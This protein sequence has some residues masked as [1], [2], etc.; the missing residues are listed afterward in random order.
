MSEPLE[1]WRVFLHPSQRKIVEKDYSGP[2][3]VLGGAGTGK[4]VVAMHRAK[5]LSSQGKGKE[6]ILLTTFTANLAADIR[7][8]FEKSAPWRNN[9]IDV[10]N[11]DAW[12]SQYL[13]EHGYPNT[14]VY[15]NVLDNVWEEAVA[16]SG[17]DLGLPI[18]FFSE[19]WAKVV[20]AEAFTLEAYAK[21]SRLGRGTR[22]DRKKRMQVWHVFEEYKNLLKE[23]HI[24]DVDSALFRCRLLIEKEA[25]FR[26]TR[27]LSSTKGRISACLPIGFFALWLEKNTEMIC[28]LWV[29]PISE[30]T[31]GRS[32][33]QS[34]ALMCADAAAF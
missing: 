12:V 32:L 17:E 8:L 3:R 26:S 11:L 33:F 7:T 34:V 6:R 4:T 29:I 14:I 27:A 25:L 23:R 2:V 31:K 10:I 16:L 13:R 18:S 21:A 20:A 30:F 19:E 28:S 22:L 1:K 15:D 24:R 9:R 5:W